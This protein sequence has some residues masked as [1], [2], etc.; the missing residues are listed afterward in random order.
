MQELRLDDSTDPAVKVALTRNDIAHQSVQALLDDLEYV[1]SHIPG[2][3]RGHA[4]R[5]VLE[6]HRPPVSESL[7]SNEGR[8]LQRE[9]RAALHELAD[10][11]QTFDDVV[12]IEEAP[13]HSIVRQAGT[14]LLMTGTIAAGGFSI[15]AILQ[16]LF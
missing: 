14:I 6:H 1:T 9:A 11:V 12:I 5:A 13:A 10:Q 8:R 4:A 15:G 7:L 16:R 3:D 2:S